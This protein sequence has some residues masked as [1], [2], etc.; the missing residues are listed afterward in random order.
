MWD[1]LRL[2]SPADL[3]LAAWLDDAA[4]GR[5][6]GSA[7]RLAR[8]VVDYLR[9]YEARYELDVPRPASG[10]DDRA[11]RRGATSCSSRRTVTRPCPRP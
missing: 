4:L 6:Q 8:H 11:G 9:R 7:F 2:F 1:G 5:R 3:L 10:Q